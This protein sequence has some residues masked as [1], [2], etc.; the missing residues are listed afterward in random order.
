MRLLQNIGSGSMNIKKFKSF[1]ELEKK[2]QEVTSGVNAKIQKKA[3]ELF[4]EAKETLPEI[5]PA[6]EKKVK[7]PKEEK[8]VIPEVP[9]EE[10]KPTKKTKKEAKKEPSVDPEISENALDYYE[11][12]A[13]ED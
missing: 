9:F 1:E 6:F 5:P 13:L 2:F 4:P 12:M 11:K 8:E 7:K 10:K 3:D